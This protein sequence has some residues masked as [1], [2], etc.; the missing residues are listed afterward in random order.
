MIENPLLQ[1]AIKN[2][3]PPR[4]VERVLQTVVALFLLGGVLV[5]L[6]SFMWGGI[7]FILAGGDEGK[8]KAARDRVTNALVG[9][10]LVF[11]AFVVLKLVGTIFGLEGL[12]VLKVMLPTLKTE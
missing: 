5:F 4:L 11:L 10:A 1:T 6:F 8:L 12:E 2:L 3:A 9:L 7:N